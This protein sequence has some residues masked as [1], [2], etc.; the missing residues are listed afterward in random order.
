[1]TVSGSGL[2]D[3]GIDRALQVALEAELDGE[4]TSGELWPGEREQFPEPIPAVDADRP[5]QMPIR[6]PRGPTAAPPLGAVLGA[7]VR[8]ESIPLPPA[9]ASETD[10]PRKIRAVA[11]YSDEAYETA[12]A[13]ALR[14][15]PAARVPVRARAPGPPRRQARAACRAARSAVSAAATL[16][17]RTPVQTPRARSWRTG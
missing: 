9:V 15:P 2:Q 5:W 6:A 1:M 14:P 16:P 10:S 17:G 12:C 7:A 11:P 3:S 13:A 8:R 4:I